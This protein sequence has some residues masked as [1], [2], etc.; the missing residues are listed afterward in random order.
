MNNQRTIDKC[1]SVMNE[2]S[3]HFILLLWR[4]NSVIKIKEERGTRKTKIEFRTIESEHL[5]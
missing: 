1:L 4:V 3:V 2:K 5:K